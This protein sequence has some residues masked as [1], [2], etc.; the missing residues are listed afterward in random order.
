MGSQLA[1]KISRIRFRRCQSSG[2][3]GLVRKRSACLN[4]KPVLR[5]PHLLAI[6][7][8]FSVYLA[9]GQTPTPV[10]APTFPTPEVDY[11]RG[12]PP[13][14]T[15]DE[16]FS[17]ITYPYHAPPEQQHRIERAARV[18]HIGSNEPQVIKLLGE[19]NYKA[20]WY[21]AIYPPPEIRT[22]R[23]LV[24]RSQR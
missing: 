9:S 20:P 4:Y 10:P 1:L 19:P 24:L 2:R 7:T 16:F 18:L 14:P 22:R 15:H 21:H 23:G 8:V 11:Y 5:Y 6:G 12:G 3:T 13:H 17:R